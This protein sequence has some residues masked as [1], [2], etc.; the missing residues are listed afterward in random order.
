M[1]FPDLL[2]DSYIG[3]P[4]DAAIVRVFFFLIA[5]VWQ[6]EQDP[7]SQ[8]VLG[9]ENRA[10]SWGALRGVPRTLHIGKKILAYNLIWSC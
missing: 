4:H 9:A 3:T 8:I 5:G 6:R 7:Q 1:A 2:R 10:K